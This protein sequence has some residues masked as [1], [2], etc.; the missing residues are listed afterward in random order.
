MELY[1]KKNMNVHFPESIR[2]SYKF[3]ETDASGRELYIELQSLLC[4]ISAYY[5]YGQ[6][7]CYLLCWVC[8]KYKQKDFLKVRDAHWPILQL[9]NNT[10]VH[11]HTRTHSK[12]SCILT[13]Q[14]N[15]KLFQIYLSFPDIIWR[16]RHLNLASGRA[17]QWLIRSRHG[18]GYADL[19][20]P[21]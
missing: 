20:C 13:S 9:S 21:C 3:K 5:F 14:W 16:D 8:F 19:F 11:V 17:A 2:L 18:L 6:T 15:L 7:Q 12:G 1:N 10:G 4:F